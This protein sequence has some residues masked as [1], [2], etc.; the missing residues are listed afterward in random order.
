MLYS[1]LLFGYDEKVKYRTR[2]SEHPCWQCFSW[3][4]EPNNDQIS[5]FFACCNVYSYYLCFPYDSKVISSNR[6]NLRIDF[7]IAEGTEYICILY[8]HFHYLLLLCFWSREATE[9]CCLIIHMMNL[10]A[11]P[12]WFSMTNATVIV[13]ADEIIKQQF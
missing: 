13:F 6:M 8:F 11:A 10:Y 5:V 7:Y 12:V 9:S 3:L 2:V 1:W 4:T